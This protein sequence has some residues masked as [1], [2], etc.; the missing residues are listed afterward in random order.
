MQSRQQCVLIGKKNNSKKKKSKQHFIDTRLSLMI[1]LK[2]SK[3]QLFTAI[4]QGAASL[5][6]L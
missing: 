5:L 1:K 4:D 2:G 3:L 6:S